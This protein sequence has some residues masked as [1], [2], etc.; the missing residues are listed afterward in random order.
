[1]NILFSSFGGSFL[2]AR[3]VFQVPEV[4]SGKNPEELGLKEDPETGLMDKRE[5]VVAR[6]QD[7]ERDL[8][9]EIAKKMREKKLGEKF[10]GDVEAAARLASELDVAIG[11]ND[12]ARAGK[13]QGKIMEQMKGIAE[14]INDKKG[15]EGV[16]AFE[17]AIKLLDGPELVE[18]KTEQIKE[19]LAIGQALTSL[20]IDFSGTIMKGYLDNPSIPFPDKELFLPYLQVD[21]IKLSIKAIQFRNPQFRSADEDQGD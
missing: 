3:L 7:Q 2:P 19:G 21:L 13:V 8:Q 9:N 4:P 6:T 17:K 20:F 18:S 15:I 16:K 1:M 10:K 12:K 5:D 11:D 14:K